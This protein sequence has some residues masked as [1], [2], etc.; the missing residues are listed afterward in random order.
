MNNFFDKFKFNNHLRY[1]RFLRTFVISFIFLMASLIYCLRVDQVKARE[2]FSN[3]ALYTADFSSSKTSTGGDV[4]GLYGN[5]DRTRAFLLLK[6]Q[7]PSLISAD[8]S[9]YSM[10][11]TPTAVRKNSQKFDNDVLAGVYVFGNS[12]YVGLY[13]VNSGGFD[14][15]ILDLTLRLNSELSAQ[16]DENVN[17][18]ADDASYRKFDQILLRINPGAKNV[19]EIATLNSKNTPDVMKLYN[20]IISLKRESDVKVEMADALDEMR[21]SLNKINEFGDRL[22]NIDNV[23]VPKLN[24]YIYGDVISKKKSDKKIKDN[25]IILSETDV[26]KKEKLRNLQ[27]VK[28]NYKFN[29]TFEGGY[30]I[31]WQKNSITNHS[32]IEDS[33]KKDDVTDLNS[34]QYFAYKKDK[35]LVDNNDGKNMSAIDSDYEWTLKDGTNISDLNISETSSRYESIMSDINNYTD[36]CTNYLMLKRKYQTELSQKLLSIE[37]DANTISDT[38]SVNINKNVLTLY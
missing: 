27:K 37:A 4:V 18:V 34:D 10:Y 35:Q 20:E 11:M 21:L 16:K 24:K 15:Q 7:D 5:K 3:K 14:K 22:D 38:A 33:M 25:Y 19:T 17:M 13:M 30:E 8:S 28:Y 6:F 9:K 26:D 1:E 12:G 31:D 23:E 36:A 2:L 29:N 32:F